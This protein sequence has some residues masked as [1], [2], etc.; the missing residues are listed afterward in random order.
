MNDRDE[1]QELKNIKY[2]SMLLSS[3]SDHPTDMGGIEK[4]LDKNNIDYR[5]I[6]SGNFCNSESLKYYNYE[7]HG[8][9]SNAEYLDTNGFFVGNHHYDLTEQIKKLHKILKTIN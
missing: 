6:V 7:I 8:R 5:P 9:V 4:I 3:V 1:C 2:K